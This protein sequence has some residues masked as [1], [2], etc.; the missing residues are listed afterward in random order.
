MQAGAYVLEARLR[1][2]SAEAAACAIACRPGPLSLADCRVDLA[3][4]ADWR[5]GETGTLLVH[6]RDR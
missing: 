2:G 4:L 5:A 1:E 6:L 3:G